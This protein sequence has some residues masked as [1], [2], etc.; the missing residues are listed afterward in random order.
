MQNNNTQTLKFNKKISINFEGGELSGETG[1]LLVEEFCNGF[2]VRKLL[3]NFLPESREGKFL[4]KKPEI[5]YQEIMRI[6]AGYTSN[7]TAYFLQKDPVFKKIHSEIGVA[8][9]ST[10]CRLEQSLGKNDLKNLQKVQKELRKKSYLLEKS[11]EVIL[12]IDTT[13]DKAS[14]NLYGANFNTHYQTTGFSPLLCFDGITGDVIKGDLRPGNTYCSKNSEKF[15]LPLFEE[16]KKNQ[17]KTYLRGDSGFAKPEI[18]ILC[19]KFDT[20]YCIKLK[21]NVK[22]VKDSFAEKIKSFTDE[23]IKTLQREGK[24]IFFEIQCKA[25]SWDKKRR[26]LCKIQ[27]KGE[28]FFPVNSAIVTNDL[29]IN[30]KEGFFFYNQRATVE[31]SIEEGKNGFSWD[32]LSHKCFNQN[33]AKFQVFL[34]AYQIMNFFKRFCVPLEKAKSSIQTLRILLLKVA[35]KIVKGGRQFVF[36]C[37]SSFPYQELWKKTLE[38]IQF[39]SL[40]LKTETSHQSFSPG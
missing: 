33:R 29:E 24:E 14:S 4:Y 23:E 13:Y 40:Y 35:S 10:C 19:E 8:S 34:L 9:S 5:I 38:N 20:T 31:N 26:I 27:W 18:Y 32:H 36:K 39:I 7:N 11:E 12:D 22:E 2:E 17:I 16:Y 21:M 15:L 30:P 1:M 28:E 25:K 37:A 6:I 3:E